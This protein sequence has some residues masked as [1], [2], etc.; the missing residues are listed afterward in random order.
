MRASVL[1]FSEAVQSYRLF[2]VRPCLTFCVDH[3]VMSLQMFLLCLLSTLVPT[4]R[5]AGHRT[6][7]STFLDVLIIFHAVSNDFSSHNQQ[8]S[9]VTK[10]AEI[11]R[12]F[13][14]DVYN[15]RAQSKNRS[16]YKESHER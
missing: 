5:R 16:R 11:I 15:Y 8:I 13:I 3:E 10:V 12:I 9:I 4:S 2:Y 7:T 1:L 6:R 14:A